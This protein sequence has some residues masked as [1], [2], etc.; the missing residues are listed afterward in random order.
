MNLFPIINKVEIKLLDESAFIKDLKLRTA[1]DLYST[2]NKHFFI[3]SIQLNHFLIKS[4]KNNIRNNFFYIKGTIK[5]SNLIIETKTSPAP[6]LMLSLWTLPLIYFFYSIDKSWLIS[7][8]LPM[9]ILLWYVMNLI[10]ALLLKSKAIYIIESI[11][12]IANKSN[13]SVN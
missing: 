7:I 13:E 4:R 10:F 1:K 8:I 5:H 2:R 3:G 11:V 12:R 6:Y 9:I